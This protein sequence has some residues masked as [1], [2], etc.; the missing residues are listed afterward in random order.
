[1]NDNETRVNTMYG[2]KALM[3][4]STAGFVVG[5]TLIDVMIW[6]LMPS[7]RILTRV[8]QNCRLGLLR[9]GKIVFDF[10]FST[11]VY[12]PISSQVIIEENH[13]QDFLQQYRP[14]L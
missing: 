4:S 9:K 5:A 1:M 10:F 6:T 8:L 2:E 11:A 14:N 7:M 13:K 12:Y 3:V